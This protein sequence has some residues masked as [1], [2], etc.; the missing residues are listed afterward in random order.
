MK[1]RHPFIVFC[2][3]AL[4]ACGPG[5]AF[6]QPAPTE[7]R[8]RELGEDAVQLTIT[9]RPAAEKG[10]PSPTLASNDCRREGGR[11]EIREIESDYLDGGLRFR[12]YTPPCYE[13]EEQR[14]FPVLYLVHGQTFNDDQWDRIGADEAADALIGSGEVAPFMIV[15]PYDRASAQPSRDPFGEVFFEELVPWIDAHYR[16]LSDREQRAVGG[17][18]R[19]A[20]WA[21]HFAMLHPELF[22]AV[23]GHSPPVFVEDAARVRVWLAG[24]PEELMPRIWLDV[25]ERDQEAILDSALW[26]AGVLNEMGIPHEWHLFTGAHSEAYWSSHVE[27]Y[28]RWYAGSW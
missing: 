15:M 9:N 11:V 2:V 12:V 8:E 27:M 22:G 13:E 20:S 1:I 25:G 17:L 4:G 26:L 3:L 16:T 7:N 10:T 19:G 21:L 23:G 6:S 14:R 18:S 24:I 28:L 5:Q